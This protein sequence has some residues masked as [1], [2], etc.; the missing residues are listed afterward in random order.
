MGGWGGVKLGVT[1]KPSTGESETGG[2]QKVEARLDSVQTLDNLNYRLTACLKRKTG[3][4]R[5]LGP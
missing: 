4:E 5:W 3:L 1:S 2:C